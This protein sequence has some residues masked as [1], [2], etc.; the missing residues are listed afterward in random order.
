MA[1]THLVV[2]FIRGAHG[3]SGECR[4]ES[5]SGDYEHLLKLKEVELRHDT[6]Q[7]KTKVEYALGGSSTVY[8]KFEGIN[9]SEEIKKYNGWE[10]LVPRKFAKPLKKGEWYVEATY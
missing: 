5:A 7:K 4:I 1:K 10:I 9:S 2:G 3:F 6:V 8:V